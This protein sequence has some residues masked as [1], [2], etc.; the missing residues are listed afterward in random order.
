MQ[1]FL[2]ASLLENTMFCARYAVNSISRKSI[3]NAAW[4]E[5]S[6]VVLV[7]TSAASLE[8]TILSGCVEHLDV[9]PSPKTKSFCGFVGWC[10]PLGRR[11]LCIECPKKGC[12]SG[13]PEILLLHLLRLCLL[14]INELKKCK[15]IPIKSIFCHRIPYV[16]G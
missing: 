13:A 14:N 5:S 6:G 1:E 4:F 15:V 8:S 10:Q 2:E 12:D 11:Y 7:V 9:L 3:W 16:Q